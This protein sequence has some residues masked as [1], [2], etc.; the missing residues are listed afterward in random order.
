MK[1]EVRGPRTCSGG[2]F[3]CVACSDKDFASRIFAPAA[4]LLALCV[5]LLSFQPALNAAPGGFG[6]LADFRADGCLGDHGS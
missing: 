3:H 2:R 4:P 5:L 6:F 1:C